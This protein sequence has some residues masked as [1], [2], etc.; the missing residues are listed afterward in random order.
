MASSVMSMGSMA[1]QGIATW[2]HHGS[3]QLMDFFLQKMVV[4]KNLVINK[5]GDGGADHAMHS[6]GPSLVDTNIFVKLLTINMVTARNVI[7]G[8]KWKIIICKQFKKQA[9]GLPSMSKW[10]SR[11]H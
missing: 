1:I 7:Y 6:V 10:K 5:F 3:K 11:I 9:F 8:Q 2:V 4:P